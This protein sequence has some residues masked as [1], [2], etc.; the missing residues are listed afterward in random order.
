MKKALCPILRGVFHRRVA[1][2]T[3]RSPIG[4]GLLQGCVNG[5]CL[6]GYMKSWPRNVM[7]EVSTEGRHG[8]SMRGPSVLSSVKR[9]TNIGFSAHNLISFPFAVIEECVVH[10][11]ITTIWPF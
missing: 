4:L 11:S 10:L 8:I 3:G 2:G 7:N 5:G 1:D 9:R 6:G